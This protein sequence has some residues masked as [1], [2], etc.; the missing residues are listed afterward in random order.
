MG[1]ALTTPTSSP[2]AGPRPH[3]ACPGP[4]VRRGRRSE[5]GPAPRAGR[6][7]RIPLAGATGG[8][9]GSGQVC[10]RVQVSLVEASMRPCPSES[11]G[12]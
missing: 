1:Q 8:H 4:P 12:G 3:P 5:A 6:A 11:S 7:R 2:Q 10:G 9:C